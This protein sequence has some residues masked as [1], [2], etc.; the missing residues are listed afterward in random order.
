MTLGGENIHSMNLGTL[1]ARGTMQSPGDCWTPGDHLGTQA[2]PMENKMSGSF[3]TSI[4]KIVNVT[5]AKLG[6]IKLVET[7]TTQK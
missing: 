3:H 4:R 7:T 1:E 5:P 2:Q 6:G